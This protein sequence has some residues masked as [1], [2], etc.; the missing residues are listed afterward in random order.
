MLSASASRAR[1]KEVHLPRPIGHYVPRVAVKME[2]AT[3]IAE[4]LIHG[5]GRTETRLTVVSIAR[6]RSAR[7]EVIGVKTSGNEPR[8]RI[9]FEPAAGK[10]DGLC[11]VEVSDPFRTQVVELGVLSTS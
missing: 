2:A 4:L 7:C 8:A 5:R 10:T 1:V 11:E 3:K 6:S 9:R